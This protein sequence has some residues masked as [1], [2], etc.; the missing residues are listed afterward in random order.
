M[1]RIAA[2]LALVKPSQFG[3]N[4]LSAA[5]KPD[6]VRIDIPMEDAWKPKHH[7]NTAQVLLSCM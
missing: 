7:V 4:V 3:L 1:V 5:G 2:V 6:S